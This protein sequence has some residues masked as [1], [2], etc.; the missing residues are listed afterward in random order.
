MVE[1]LK[2]LGISTIGILVIVILFF[3]GKEIWSILKAIRL[4]MCH[5]I[6]EKM[7]D[8]LDESI[9]KFYLPIYQR[10]IVME[11]LFIITR[12]WNNA[13]DEY[14]NT[15]AGIKSKNKKALRNIVVRRF[16]LPLNKDIESIILNQLHY[17]LQEDNTDY[18]KLLFHYIMWRTL[19][20]ATIDGEIE[21]YSASSFLVFPSEEAEKQKQF[22]LEL[23]NKQSLIREKIIRL[24]GTF[25][26]WFSKK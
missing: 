12:Y 25:G 21:S 15:K 19:E 20:E 4:Q 16:F 22:C 3:C 10:L 17:K 14:D 26:K 11:N 6:L 9:S 24:E 18:S 7:L 8:E 5:H 1:I 13:N 2:Q 23:L